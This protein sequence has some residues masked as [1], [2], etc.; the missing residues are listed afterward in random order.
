MRILLLVNKPQA[1][2]QEIFAAHLGNHFLQIGHRVVLLSLYSGDFDLNFKGSH[3]RLNLNS[4][5]ETNLPWHWRRLYEVICGFKPDLIQANGGDTVK[6][7]A[8][9]KLLFPITSKLVFNNG[10]VV[11]YYLTSGLKKWFYQRLLASWHGAIS[12]SQHAQLD[13]AMLLP[14]NCKQIH[15][16]IGVPDQ[17]FYLSS[18]TDFQVFVHIGGFTPEKNHVELLQ[19]FIAYLKQDPSVQLWLFGEGALKTDMELLADQVAPQA[20]RFFGSV[21]N[22]WSLVPKNS[23]FLLPSQIEG[24]PAVVAEALLAKVSVIAYAVGGIPEMAS[25]IPTISLVTPGDKASFL[26]AMTYWTELPK[27]ILNRNLE[28]S[29]LEAKKKFD[30]EKISTRFLEFYQSLCE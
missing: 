17:E 10:G 11:S 16:P 1:R 25:A 13:L 21:S 7:L 28:V 6:F 29:A 5:V 8:L 23:I 18:A 4:R 9:A 19:L 22:P 15:I 2:G 3:I 30:L 26:S 12:V 27:E 24:M 20:I 14:K